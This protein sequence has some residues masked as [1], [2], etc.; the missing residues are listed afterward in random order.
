MADIAPKYY[1]IHHEDIL[2]GLQSLDFDTIQSRREADAALSKYVSDMGTRMFL[3]KNLY[4]KDKGRLGFRMNLPVLASEVEEV[5]ESL[6]RQTV[7][8]GET[9]FIRGG[10]SS[11]IKDEDW[12]DVQ[13]HFPN[14]QLDTIP[15]AGHWLHAEAPA[16]FYN[17]T[18]KFL[19]L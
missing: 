17:S 16:E 1:P 4:W 7:F 18:S 9:L 3:L 13:R 2:K 11:Y 10:R 5:G 14:A 19:I 15:S 8:K 12:M 6:P